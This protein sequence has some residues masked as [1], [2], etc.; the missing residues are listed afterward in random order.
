MTCCFYDDKS[1]DPAIAKMMCATGN[2]QQ[3]TKQGNTDHS[4][5]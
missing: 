5:M 2:R 3:A 1:I 4:I